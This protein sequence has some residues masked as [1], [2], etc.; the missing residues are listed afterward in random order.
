LDTYTLQQHK[1][2][3]TL[4]YISYNLKLVKLDT[5]IRVLTEKFNL[6]FILN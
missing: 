4:S 6:I 1:K 5:L 3:R 2:R